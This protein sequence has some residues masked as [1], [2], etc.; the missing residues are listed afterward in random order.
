MLINSNQGLKN[1]I[2]ASVTLDYE[3]IR[4]KIQ[5]V[6]RE[7]LNRIFSK[8][9]ILAVSSHAA[10]DTMIELREILEEA[11]AHLALLEY[12]P[13]GQLQF[14]S[15]GIRMAVNENFKSAYE[16]QIHDLKEICS[17]QGWG[18]VE[19]AL[20]FLESTDDEELLALWQATDT[21]QKSQEALLG[22]LADF[23]KF[24]NINNSRVLFNKFI[25][26]IN[27]VQ[28]DI[29]EPAIGTELFTKCISSSEGLYPR[30]KKMACRA[31]AY[32]TASIGF[33]DSL[34]ILSDNGPLVIDGLKLKS[35]K[36]TA[37]AQ[38]VAII[39]E[40]YKSRAEASL[41]DLVEFCQANVDLL[42]EFKSSLN[43]IEDVSTDNTHIPRNDES[44]GGVFF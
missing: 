12:I 33:M 6:E 8:S 18:A 7:I 22:S 5:L 21:F 4:P 13:F 44:W 16:W 37:P 43:F 32:H 26:I 17:R 40:N 28:E 11:E 34:L 29:I 19:S 35:D 42:P 39:A 15:A 9:L 27:D 2:P 30:I 1:Y 14:D 31:L 38:L 24:V 23:Q 20:L 41:R 25:P 36:K 3:D 10:S